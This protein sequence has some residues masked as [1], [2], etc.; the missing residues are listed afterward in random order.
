MKPAMTEENAVRC[1]DPEV[2]LVRVQNIDPA[3]IQ[4][5]GEF[6]WL[7]E[8]KASA[9]DGVLWKIIEGEVL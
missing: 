7:S 9:G 1:S 5:H 4:Y 2:R 3:Q 8:E 6:Q